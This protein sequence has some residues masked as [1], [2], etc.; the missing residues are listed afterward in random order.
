MR[1]GLVSNRD[2]SDSGCVRQTQIRLALPAPAEPPPTSAHV[3]IRSAENTIF[4]IRMDQCVQEVCVVA[5]TI[6]KGS[7]APQSKRL[8]RMY[9]I[10]ER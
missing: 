9:V 2:S 4:P 8:T 10:A 6:D 1:V 7:A 5:M 3:Q